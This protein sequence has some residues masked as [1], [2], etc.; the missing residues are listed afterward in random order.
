[1]PRSLPRFFS[2]VVLL[3]GIGLCGCANNDPPLLATLT[4]KKDGSHFSGKV[5]RRETN[6]ITV[7]APS[8]DT[9][10]FLNNELSD[11]KYGAPKTE[12]PDRATRAGVPG[13]GPGGAPPSVARKP[14]SAT[15]AIPFAAG[16]EFPIRINGFVDS[17]CMHEGELALGLMDSDM[18][19]A[20]GDVLIPEGAS[21]TM[22][23]REEKVADNRIQMRFELGSADFDGQHFLVSSSKGPLEPGAVATVLGAPL[24]SPE[25]KLQGLSVH[26]ANHTYIAFKAATPTVF[27]PS[28]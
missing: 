6:S 7:T 17:C 18:K 11:I 21:L 12:F 16:T 28:K 2:S 26:I 5:V 14:P 15:E 10:T 22:V 1:M 9:R 3:C 13:A 27:K 4:L 20:R 19:S 23:L 24:G 25:A 8:G